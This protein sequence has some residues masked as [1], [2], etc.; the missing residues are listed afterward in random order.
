MMINGEEAKSLGLVT[1]VVEKASLEK[2]VEDF[3]Q[4]L[5]TSAS[6]ESLA[7]TKKMV[8]EVQHMKLEEALEFASRKMPLHAVP[9]I[10]K[11]ELKHFLASNR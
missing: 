2:A 3:A 8:S 4:Q 10:A 1:R 7:V 6:S 9:K 11:R 5:I